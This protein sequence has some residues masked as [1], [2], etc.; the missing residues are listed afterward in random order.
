MAA[1]FLF[2]DPFLAAEEGMLIVVRQRQSQTDRE[3]SPLRGFNCS[4]VTSTQAQ[5]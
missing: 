4:P 3:H 1:T 2:Y 5:Q